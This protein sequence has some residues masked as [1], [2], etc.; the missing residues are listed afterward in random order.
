MFITKYIV[1]WYRMQNGTLP[2]YINRVMFKPYNISSK[3]FPFYKVPPEKL[4]YLEKILKTCLKRDSNRA[5]SIGVFCLF[6]M[7]F[8]YNGD[9]Y[10]STYTISY[11]PP[12][13][14]PKQALQY[15]SFVSHTHICKRCSS[16]CLQKESESNDC[17]AQ[18]NVTFILHWNFFD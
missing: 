5:V 10:Q 9:Y 18:R 14:P 3:I 8:S 12:F 15:L 2:I 13:P 1:Q 16:L 6:F 11:T 7:P 4:R 17:P